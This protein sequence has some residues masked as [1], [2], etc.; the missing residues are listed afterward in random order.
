MTSYLDNEGLYCPTLARH[1]GP[2]QITLTDY[3]RFGGMSYPG[4]NDILHTVKTNEGDKGI[5]VCPYGV[6]ADSPIF[7]PKLK[8]DGQ[9]SMNEKKDNC[10]MR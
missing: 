1:F 5:S 4:D 8:I 2:E 9:V 10:S 7:L 6:Y 3:F